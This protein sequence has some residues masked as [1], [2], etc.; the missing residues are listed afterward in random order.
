MLVSISGPP[1]SGKTTLHKILRQSYQFDAPVTFVPDLVRQAIDNIGVDFAETDRQAFQDYVGFA[2]YVAELRMPTGRTGILDKSLIDAVAYWDVLV[3][4]KRPVWASLVHRR[5]D[6][7]LLCGHEE[8]P[9]RGSAVDLMHSALRDR[10]AKAVA[11]VAQ[12]ADSKL[13][14]ISGS[15][16]E[17][18]ATAVGHIG[19][20]LLT[21]GSGDTYARARR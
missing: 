10:L 16:A 14:W 13:V 8:V 19:D 12:E 3:G 20:P 11:A 4:G 7:V 5:Y 9:V 17:R 6:L 18:V 15:L 2:Q 21:R 1:R